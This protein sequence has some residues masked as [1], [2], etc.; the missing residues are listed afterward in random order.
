MG[1]GLKVLLGGM[2]R[3]KQPQHPPPVNPGSSGVAHA[4]PQAGLHV[5]TTKQ[6]PALSVP[7]GLNVGCG[8]GGFLV[9]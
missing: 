4:V 8:D 1:A 2:R 5:A 9:G 6:F 3:L 7:L